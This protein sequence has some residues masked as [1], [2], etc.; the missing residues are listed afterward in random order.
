MVVLKAVF[1]VAQFHIPNTPNGAGSGEI[2]KFLV[3]CYSWVD[4]LVATG[5]N[6]PI[7]MYN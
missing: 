3:D 6:Y 1:P 4:T 7:T 2:Y 5:C